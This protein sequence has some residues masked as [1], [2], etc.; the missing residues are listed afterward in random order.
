MNGQFEISLGS[1]LYVKKRKM[2]LG[3]G[4]VQVKKNVGAVVF[5]GRGGGIIWIKTSVLNLD[6]LFWGWGQSPGKGRPPLLIDDMMRDI[7][8]RP[9]PEDNAKVGKLN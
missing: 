6:Q 9:K 5:T 3:G 4:R 7:R 2:D 8:E 1:I